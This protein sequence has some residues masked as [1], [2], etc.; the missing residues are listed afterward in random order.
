MVKPGW[1][2]VGEDCEKAGV[3]GIGIEGGCK[4]KEEGVGVGVR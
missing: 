4:W 2:S 1:D 3:W